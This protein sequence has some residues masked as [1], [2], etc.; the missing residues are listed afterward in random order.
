MAEERLQKLMAAAGVGSRRACEELIV[1]GRVRV[2]GQVV[3]ELGAK[4]DLARDHISVDGKPLR[5]PQRHVY[6]KLHK[7]RGMLSDSGDD[8]AG[9]RAVLEL[10][11]A[12][13]RRVFP[14]GRLDLLSEGLMLFTDDGD[15]AHKLTHPRFQHPKTYFVLTERRPSESELVQFRTGIDLP[16]GRTAPATIRVVERPP[17][18]LRLGPGV[19]SGIW[20]EVGL[21]EGKKRQIRH[22][23]AAIGH[24]T[25]RLSLI[26]I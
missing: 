10:L 6:L 25:L 24:S 1:A 14:V 2:N 19:T 4:A 22:M 5:R 21:R 20:L 23:L 8:P 7:P 9:R 18:D 11:P 3:S 12:E 13:M 15:L 26:H 17:A 16:E